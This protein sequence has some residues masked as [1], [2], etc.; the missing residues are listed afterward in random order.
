MRDGKKSNA[1]ETFSFGEVEDYTLSVNHINVSASPK[2]PTTITVYP[3]PVSSW[4]NIRFGKLPSGKVSLLINELGQVVYTG[5]AQITGENNITLD[6]QNV[7]EGAFTLICRTENWQE[8]KSILI[9][10]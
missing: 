1:C 5:L 8:T 9:F 7:R 3:N 2:A 4:L 10:H 6:C